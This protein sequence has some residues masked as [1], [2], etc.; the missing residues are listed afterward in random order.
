M[1]ST[2]IGSPLLA[3]PFL[4]V[5]MLARYASPPLG[6]TS[7]IAVQRSASPCAWRTLAL[8]AATQG[9]KAL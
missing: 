6:D 5:G 9:I 7:E 4:F 1:N 2:G 3:R 8:P